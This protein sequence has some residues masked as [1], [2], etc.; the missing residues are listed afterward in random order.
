MKS[1]LITPEREIAF[2]KSGVPVYYSNKN[3]GI[4]VFRDIPDNKLYIFYPNSQEYIEIKQDNVDYLLFRNAEVIDKRLS[5]SAY[6]L[7]L[8]FFESC[9]I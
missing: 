9:I 1:K 3:G 7:F 5:A 8:L 4:V 2:A 6:F